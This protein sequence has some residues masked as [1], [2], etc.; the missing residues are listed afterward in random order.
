MATGK[1]LASVSTAY[2]TLQAGDIMFW[3]RAGTAGKTTFTELAS[4]IMAENT[5][6]GVQ[7]ENTSAT[8]GTDIA[9][10]LVT[11]DATAGDVTHG[12]PAAADMDELPMV[13]FYRPDSSGNAVSLDGNGSETILGQAVYSLAP[14]Q[15]LFLWS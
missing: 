4:E 2:S 12:L 9:A 6:Y 5:P 15:L 13:A 8:L 1:T 14:G 11:V 3:E 7:S 10:K